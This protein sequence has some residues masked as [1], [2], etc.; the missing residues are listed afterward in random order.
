MFYARV[1]GNVVSTIKYK[2]LNGKKLQIIQ[3]V[4]LSTG[5]DIGRP[6]VAADTTDAGVGEYVG[7]EDG[8]EATW[9]FEG[10]DTPS[11]ATIVSIIETVN[12]YNKQ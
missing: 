6:I 7:Y 10:N 11:D 4:N 8:M 5:K 1:V 2:G 3:P 12:I 9:P